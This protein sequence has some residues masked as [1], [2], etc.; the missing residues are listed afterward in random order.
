MRERTL[1]TL[2]TEIAL[3]SAAESDSPRIRYAVRQGLLVKAAPRVIMPAGL[4]ADPRAW[5]VAVQRGDPDLPVTGTAAL[6]CTRGL[7]PRFPI[8][9]IGGAKRRSTARVRFL[10]T[11]DIPQEMVL[12]TAAGSCTV[13]EISVLACWALGDSETPCEALREGWTTVARLRDVASGLPANSWLGRAATDALEDLS[14]NPWSPAELDLHRLLRDAGITGWQGNPPLRLGDGSLRYPDVMFREKR[15][16]IEVNGVAFHGGVAALEK[17]AR[18]VAE[19]QR[20]GWKVISITPSML[21]ESPSD[22]IDLV[23]AQLRARA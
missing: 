9:M 15:L 11:S 1:S 5:I 8:P 3:L 13:D 22:V 10:R 6:W 17:D 14:G 4:A 19:F 20:A 23:R 21:R 16:L 12:S 2:P 18:R 7:T